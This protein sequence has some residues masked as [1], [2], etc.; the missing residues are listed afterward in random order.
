MASLPA[1][2][3]LLTFHVPNLM[4]LFRCL[5]RTKVTVQVRGFLC[6][7]FV[8]RGVVSTSPNPQA[9]WQPLV[10]CPR[11]LIQ[12]IRR[13]PPYWRSFFH[14]QPENTPCR[15]D[16]DPLITG[17]HY[18][19]KLHCFVLNYEAEYILTLHKEFSLFSQWHKFAHKI[20]SQ[21]ESRG[22]T[23]SIFIGF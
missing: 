21:K 12:Y 23:K 19:V 22:F 3:R 17:L 15:D 1:L 16:R 14:P 8:K 11:L 2:Y 10:G 6:E 7:Y 13:Y 5:G 9:G 20:I 18:Q 4:S